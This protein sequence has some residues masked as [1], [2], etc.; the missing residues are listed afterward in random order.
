[1]QRAGVV[2][3]GGARG[4]QNILPAIARLLDQPNGLGEIGSARA[5]RYG[6]AARQPVLDVYIENARRIGRNL[7]GGII[8]ER[9]AVAAVV[10]DA[11]HL[12]R[13]FV[14]ELRQRRG[15]QVGFENDSDALLRQRGGAVEQNAQ[16][17]L[18]LR[19]ALDP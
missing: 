4:L 7:L 1:R 10:I 2:A 16:Q 17:S 6:G 11:E 8:A 9:G 5:E 3:V 12:G 18:R 13:E 19:S 14:A 15:P